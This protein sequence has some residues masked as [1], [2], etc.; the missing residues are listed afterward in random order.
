MPWLQSSRYETGDTALDIPMRVGAF[1]DEIQLDYF[2]F[3]LLRPPSDLKFECLETL[4]TNYPN[5]WLNRYQSNRYL[6]L[7][8]VAALARGTN[9]PFYWNHGRFLRPF[10]K[11]QRR[12]F[13]EAREFQILNGL[14][15]PVHSPKGEIGIFNLVAKNKVQLREATEGAQ[16]QIMS[17]AYDTHDL[18]MKSQR[19]KFEQ[20]QTVV[21]L[22]ARERECLAWT[23]EGKTA[24][25]IAE[26]IGLS[27]DTV[28]HY[29]Q[30][31]TLKL[32]GSNKYHAAVKALRAGILS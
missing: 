7:D 20:N 25:E 3:V 15:I 22:S 29:A 27:V 16:E 13:N 21:D 6:D 18:V 32:G 10:R 11:S 14:S 9:R 31:S 1:L 17:L 23:L 26:I 19:L 12:V 28:N 2:S 8:P 30:T 24:R 5:E 4:N